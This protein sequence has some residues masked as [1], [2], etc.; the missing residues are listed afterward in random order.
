M[1]IY[2]SD[3]GRFIPRT[4]HPRMIHPPE[5]SPPG[6]FTPP[7]VHHLGIFLTFKAHENN[8]QNTSKKWLTLV[9]MIPNLKI[10]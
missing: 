2:F 7:N 5:S 10:I 3:L 9:C 8:V 4:F 6:R 1:H